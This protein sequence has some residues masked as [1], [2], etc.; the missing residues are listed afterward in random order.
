MIGSFS[1]SWRNFLIF[2]I[3]THREI[4]VEYKLM[5]CFPRAFQVFSYFSF[6]SRCFYSAYV[7]LIVPSLVLRTFSC[8]HLCPNKCALH[9]PMT[10]F[11]HFSFLCCSMSSFGVLR[12]STRSSSNI[13]PTLKVENS[14]RCKTISDMKVILTMLL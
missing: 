14:T 6:S 9:L 1:M 3:L 5:T 7:L 12:A 13:S 2:L 10:H 11:K 8:T 4:P